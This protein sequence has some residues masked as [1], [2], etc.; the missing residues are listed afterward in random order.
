MTS[1]TKLT[2][3][4]YATTTFSNAI[5]PSLY[6]EEF[7]SITQLSNL[8]TLTISQVHCFDDDAGKN[9]HK[10]RLLRS[11]S[12][13]DL[14]DQFK[15]DNNFISTLTSLTKLS[16]INCGLE[17]SD[18]SKI[19]I[20]CQSV[21]DLD[22]RNNFVLT[23]VG[24]SSIHQLKKIESFHFSIWS[25]LTFGNEF[26]PDNYI[27]DDLFYFDDP[28]TNYIKQQ[29]EKLEQEKLNGGFWDKFNKIRTLTFL[30]LGGSSIGDED[31]AQISPRIQPFNYNIPELRFTLVEK[32]EIKCV[33][34]N[35]N[36]GSDEDFHAFN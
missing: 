18:I 26:P 15:T 27:N 35:N 32:E 6:F 28:T 11:L 12:L 19:C 22:V 23:S 17:D 1:L 16:I 4:A 21:E 5:S 13:L 34:N 25:N 36:K 3:S 9:F 7:D 8:N 31:L 20:G 10:L 2:L 29:F 24:L 33:I 14:C 30:D